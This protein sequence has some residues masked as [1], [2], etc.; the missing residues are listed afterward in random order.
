MTDDDLSKY[1]YKDDAG[2]EA[3]QAALREYTARRAGGE[4]APTKPRERK[5]V[6]AFGLPGVYAP[7]I[8]YMKARIIARCDDSTV[9]HGCK[10]GMT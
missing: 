6:D 5:V 2:W 3:I 1:D 8:E 7:G 9:R 4:P 10:G